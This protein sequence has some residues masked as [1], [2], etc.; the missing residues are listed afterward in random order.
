MNDDPETSSYNQTKLDS[1]QAVVKGPVKKVAKNP[2][3]KN[4]DEEFSYYMSEG[5][6]TCRIFYLLELTSRGRAARKGCE[7]KVTISTT[8]VLIM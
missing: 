6:S 1:S 2:K 4:L 7:A 3:V 8:P 5:A